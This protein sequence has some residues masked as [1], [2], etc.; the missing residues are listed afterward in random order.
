MENAGRVQFLTEGGRYL[1][2]EHGMV[3]EALWAGLP[4]PTIN[5]DATLGARLN[6]S[7]AAIRSMLWRLA[8]AR[9]VVSLSRLPSGISMF[10]LP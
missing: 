3:G 1:R 8:M 9:K 6:W 5:A 2:L 10:S 7:A 4:V